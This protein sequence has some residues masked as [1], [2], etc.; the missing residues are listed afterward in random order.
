MVHYSLDPENTTKSCKSRDLNVQV[1]FKNMHETAQA[2][3]VCLYPKATKYL[4]DD[5]LQQQCEPFHCFSG[6]VGGCVQAKSQGLTQGQQPKKSA[7]FLL[8]MLK[9]AESNAEVKGL[10]V[11]FLV[12]EHIQVNKVPKTQHRTCRVHGQ[13][14][15][16]GSP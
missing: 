9:N 12:I 5:T 2:I 11:D 7:E 1:H 6:R 8:N 3:R 16:V 4:K 14:P 15:H 10:D 13:S